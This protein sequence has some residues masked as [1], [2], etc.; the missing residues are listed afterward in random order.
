MKLKHIPNALSLTRLF[1]C[2]PLA[3]LSPFSTI[4]IV[5]FVLAGITDTLDGKL[6]RRIKNGASELGAILDSVADVC[7]VGVI[8]FA[9]M[10]KMEIW[11]WLWVTFICVLAL[12][13]IAST[14]I[15]FLKFKE[16]ISLHTISLKTLFTGFFFYPLLYY[17]IG[18][19]LFMNIFSTVLIACALLVVTE[20][21]LIIATLKKPA[22]NIKSIFDVREVNREAGLSVNT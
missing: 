12:K 10:P 3:I 2:I 17:F 4:Y 20:E 9:I 21:I 11:G 6:A 22:R 16:V 7:M 1:L 15:G 19:G 13:V 5:L 14:G 18:A 8:I